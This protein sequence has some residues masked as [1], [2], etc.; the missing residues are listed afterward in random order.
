MT[1][2]QSREQFHQILS[3]FHTAMLVTQGDD[4]ELRARPMSIASVEADDEL[5]FVT[6]VASQKAGDVLRNKRVVV[7]LQGPSKFASVSGEAELIVNSARGKALWKESFRPWFPEG[8]SDPRL[9]LVRVRPRSADFWDLSG[10]HGVRFLFKAV[11]HAIEGKRMGDG[12]DEFH[13]RVHLQ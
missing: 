7:V 10:L 1:H 11:R 5:W 2:L 13:A 4:G 6:G 3:S 8:P 12:P 9:A